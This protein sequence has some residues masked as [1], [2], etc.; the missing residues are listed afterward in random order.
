MFTDVAV[1]LLYM[2]HV[3]D[4]VFSIGEQICERLQRG[5]EHEVGV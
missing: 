1:S 5:A 2:G 3:Y 4:G